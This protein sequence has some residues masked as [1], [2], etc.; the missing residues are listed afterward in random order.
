MDLKTRFATA[1]RIRK[2]VQYDPSPGEKPKKAFEDY[3][4]CQAM[5]DRLGLFSPNEMLEDI[6]TSDLQYV[7][8]AKML[9]IL[10]DVCDYQAHS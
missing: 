2:D 3:L 6:S 4:E 7:E 5:V 10:E 1:E 9:S 8:S